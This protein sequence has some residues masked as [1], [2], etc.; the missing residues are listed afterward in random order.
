[1]TLTIEEVYDAAL[2]RSD[3]V[4][5]NFLE[6]GRSLRRLFDM[7]RGL[8]KQL[9]KKR[10]LSRNKARCLVNVSKVFDPLPI[11][12]SRLRKIGRTKLQMIA[13]HVT[14][15]NMEDLLQLAENCSAQR[16]ERTLR[17]G[18]HCEKTRRVQMSVTAAEYKELEDALVQFGG[19][20][21]GQGI[22]HKE[23][24]LM[25][26]ARAATQNIKSY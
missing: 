24:A 9:I 21:S 14:P 4:E 23:V 13:K 25:N 5:D 15:E 16:L 22:K 11:P 10:N 20:R 1:M 8:F 6:L 7:D 19:V 18:T 17:D 3:D 2:V 26:M 12:R